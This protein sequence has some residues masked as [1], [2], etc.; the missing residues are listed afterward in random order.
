MIRSR[1]GFSDPHAR[2][3]YKSNSSIS[4]VR[5]LTGPSISFLM[6][7]L[8]ERGPDHRGQGGPWLLAATVATRVAAASAALKPASATARR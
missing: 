4:L 1:F 5:S 8:G 2:Y 7:A 6:L 3:G